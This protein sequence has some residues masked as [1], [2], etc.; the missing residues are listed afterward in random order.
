MCA[1]R[2]SAPQKRVFSKQMTL[3]IVG[4]QANKC[5]QRAEVVQ[6]KK[7]NYCSH[8][9]T[10]RMEPIR[11]TRNQCTFYKLRRNEKYCAINPRRHIIRVHHSYRSLLCSTSMFRQRVLHYKHS[12]CIWMAKKRRQ[13]EERQTMCRRKMRARQP[14]LSLK[15]VKLRQLLLKLCIC[16]PVRQVGQGSNPQM[17]CSRSI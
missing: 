12:R 4:L 9:R 14:C 11:M 3:W 5:E 1:I 7:A 8:W 2:H 15:R 10:N 16:L 17:D 13:Q 6:W